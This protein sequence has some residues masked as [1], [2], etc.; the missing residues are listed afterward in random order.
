[1]RQIYF[2]IFR[3]VSLFPVGM[4]LRRRRGCV[5]NLNA[6][7]ETSAWSQEDSS[8]CHLRSRT[9][10]N[11]ALLLLLL[12]A[13]YEGGGEEKFFYFFF[14]KTTNINE[15]LHWEITMCALPDSICTS[16]MACAIMRAS[17]NIKAATV[18]AK[19]FT[20]ITAVPPLQVH[21]KGIYVKYSDS[22]SLLHH[23]NSCW[24]DHIQQ[25]PQH[26]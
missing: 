12:L 9:A 22:V 6:E 26:I 1:M 13:K 19:G 24:G 2:M 17:I 8:L 11:P 20:S 7:Q 3:N 10:S 5:S 23:I 14:L 18:T 4:L 25:W 21:R 16:L 15:V